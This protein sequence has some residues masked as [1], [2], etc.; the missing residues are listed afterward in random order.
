MQTLEAPRFPLAC[1]AAGAAPGKWCGATW[2][3]ST[4]AVSD[5]RALPAHHVRCWRH[6]PTPDAI[7]AEVTSLGVDRNCAGPKN[8]VTQSSI[9]A[10]LLA[11][12]TQG[13]LIHTSTVLLPRPRRN[14]W[15]FQRSAQASRRTSTFANDPCGS[16]RSSGRRDHSVSAWT[17]GPYYTPRARSGVCDEFP[18]CDQSRIFL[19]HG[20]DI[21]LPRRPSSS[22][23]RGAPVDCRGTVLTTEPP[24][25]ASPS[26][27]ESELQ[28]RAEPRLGAAGRVVSAGPTGGPPPITLSA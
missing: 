21:H 23:G 27:A 24:R 5:T 12:D 14:E 22:L 28:R 18:S 25:S 26:L 15:G 11:H 8:L 10:D 13:N 6:Y 16:C 1:L 20:A 3:R 19:E 9:Q 7:F 2:R 4:R 17:R